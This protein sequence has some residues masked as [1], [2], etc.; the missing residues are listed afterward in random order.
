MAL[1]PVALAALDSGN[2]EPVLIVYL[3]V[4]SDPVRAMDGP[5]STTFSGTGDPDLDGHSFDAYGWLVTAVSPVSHSEGGSDTVT[6]TLSGLIDVDSA[7][8]NAIGDRTRYKG[9]IARLWQGL[10]D[11][12]GA[13]F[14][15]WPLYTGYMMVPRFSIRPDG[16]T[17]QLEIENYTAVLTDAPSRTYLSQADYDPGDLSAEASVAIF[18]GG[19]ASALSGAGNRG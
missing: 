6:I 9:R 19:S 1:P 3:D 18:N 10:V 14:A 16:A 7:L 8:M 5:Y 11:E 2:I 13:F 4:A 12:T 17:I 15:V